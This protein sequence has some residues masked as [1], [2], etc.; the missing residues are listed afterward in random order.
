[1]AKYKG[2]DII[3][4]FP[5]KHIFHKKCLL[6][7]LKQSNKCPLCKHDITEDV[8]KINLEDNYEEDEN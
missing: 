6:K 8:N 5:C 3:K 4:E 1:M 7:W 2:S